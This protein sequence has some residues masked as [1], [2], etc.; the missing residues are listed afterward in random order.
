MARKLSPSGEQFLHQVLGSEA[1]AHIEAINGWNPPPEHNHR[2]NEPPIG[3]CGPLLREIFGESEGNKLRDA[4]NADADMFAR[5]R[6]DRL[7]AQSLAFPNR[8]RP[9]TDLDIEHLRA[10]DAERQR[11]RRQRIREAKE[12]AQSHGATLA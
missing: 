7:A 3:N 8:S 2:C 12:R 5:A 4:I 9:I 1:E 6:A 11:R 10:K